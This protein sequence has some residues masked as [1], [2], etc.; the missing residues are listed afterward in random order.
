MKETNFADRKIS[1]RSFSNRV[2]QLIKNPDNTFQRQNQAEGFGQK[3]SENF[4]Q[5]PK[6]H[7]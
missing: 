6:T 5:K 1:P 2:P 7:S 3:C 4:G